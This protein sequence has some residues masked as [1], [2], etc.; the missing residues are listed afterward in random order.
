MLLA[1][2]DRSFCAAVQER[3]GRRSASADYTW[4]QA[5]LIRVLGE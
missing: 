4:D 1:D 5:T 3:C 2:Q